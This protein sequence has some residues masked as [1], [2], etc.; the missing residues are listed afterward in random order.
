L[1]DRSIDD[2]HSPDAGLALDQEAIVHDA[3]RL[4]LAQKLNETAR[5]RSHDR[6]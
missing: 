1:I 5:G 3:A 4:W 2:P 6:R